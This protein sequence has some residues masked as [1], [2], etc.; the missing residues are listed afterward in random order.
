V[1]RCLDEAMATM[2]VGTLATAAV[3]RLEGGGR[4]L[5]WANAGHPPPVLLLPD[6]RV[7]ALDHGDP[8]GDL[9]LGVDAT[10]VR[11]EATVELAPGTTVL[12]HTDGLVE[13]RGSTLD[14][15]TDRL[16][17][18][19][20]GLAGTPLPELCDELLARLVEGTPQDD[21][22]LVAVTVGAG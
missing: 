20:A 13:R 21:V 10:A 12:L 19:L 6:G 22:A 8:L 16:H 4:R 3:V 1:L 18:T 9:V 5:R 15:D 17:R 11:R 14:A 7:T 2:H